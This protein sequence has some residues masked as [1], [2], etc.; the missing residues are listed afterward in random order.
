MALLRYLWQRS[1]DRGHL[2]DA[3]NL[4]NASSAPSPILHSPWIAEQFARLSHRSERRCT[5]C[6]RQRFTL[7]PRL[8]YCPFHG[9]WSG[10]GPI[11]I[12]GVALFCYSSSGL[13]SR[14]QGLK[15]EDL[16]D[17]VHFCTSLTPFIVLSM[18]LPRPVTQLLIL[19][20][21][22]GVCT[23]EVRAISSVIW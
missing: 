11:H 17:C 21:P 16:A 12:P 5:H 10:Q 4:Q 7:S 19:A 20:Y 13:H 23:S 8:S 1:T 15:F 22:E 6:S 9:K 18:R 2:Y 14:T 3:L